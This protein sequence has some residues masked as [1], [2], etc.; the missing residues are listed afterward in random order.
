MYCLD[1]TTG[2]T[3]WYTDHQLLNQNIM[4]EMFNEL[5]LIVAASNTPPAN[6]GNFSLKTIV[7]DK[8][9]GKV[10]FDKNFGQASGYYMIAVD[11]KKGTV[12]LQ[13]YNGQRIRLSPDDGKPASDAG[14]GTSPTGSAPVV[15][16][17]GIN[18]RIII[19]GNIGGRIEISD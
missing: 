19:Q 6:G 13:N 9:T 10:K 4:V 7:I 16:P 15:L 3:L 8:A 12:D 1:K 5:P 18:R 11:W 14:S 2:K 17:G